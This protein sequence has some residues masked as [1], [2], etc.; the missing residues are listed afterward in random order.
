MLSYD[1]LKIVGMAVAMIVVW[2]LI[3]TMTATRITAA[4]QFTVVNYFGNVSMTQFSGVDNRLMD[5]YN[6]KIFS[7]E[8]IETTTV[9]A[10]SYADQGHTVLEARVATQEGD[11][12]FVPDIQKVDSKY[13][14]TVNGEKEERYDSYLQ[15][16]VRRYGYSLYNLDPNAENG[17]FKGM[18]QFLNLYY[19]GGYEKGE[20]NK[21]LVEA[22]F[23]ARIQKN[24]DKRFKT[25]E[26]IA[27]GIQDEIKRVEK[28]RNALVEFYGYV[29]TGL[30]TFTHTTVFDRETGEASAYLNGI[31][32]INLCPNKDTMGGLK[33]VAC[34]EEM[35]KNAE[36]E[37]VKSKT[38]QNM[39]VAFF[40]FKEVEESFQYENL[41]YV[42]Y[43]IRSV[44][45]VEK[46]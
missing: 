9:D 39:N 7:Y 28:Y 20:L 5:A 16:L 43:I 4:Q 42:N 25:D 35:V 34:Y 44:M 21:S 27:Q 31:Y 46:D 29:E 10:P 26:Q 22:D 1:W 23:L 14:I 38:A 13:E 18:E 3:F 2:S 24:K 8:V 40:R 36:G 30:V 19:T 45:T 15:D 32:S 37:D 12:I 11:V 6:N 41:L 17:F 33:S